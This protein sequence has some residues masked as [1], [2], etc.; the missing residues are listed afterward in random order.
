MSL[1]P[2]Q[3]TEAQNR[4]RYFRQHGDPVKASKV[5]AAWQAGEM[6]D[7]SLM[8]DQGVKTDT[9][10]AA[11]VDI[12]IPPRT[13]KGSAQKVWAGFAAKVTDIDAEVLSR[14]SRDD[15]IGAL[16]ARGNIPKEE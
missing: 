2:E 8:S 13:G 6:P 3:L 16:E 10:L 14:M 7:P 9:N 11:G 15:I 12:E 1:T 4:E 5:R